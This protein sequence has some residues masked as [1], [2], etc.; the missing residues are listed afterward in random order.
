M[1]Q[2]RCSAL[3]TM[4]GPV[5]LNF[6]RSQGSRLELAKREYKMDV[7]GRIRSRKTE[8]ALSQV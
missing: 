8:Q 2:F 1:A 4:G 7:E 6:E 3:S 5:T